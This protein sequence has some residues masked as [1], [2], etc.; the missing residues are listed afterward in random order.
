MKAYYSTALII[1]ALFLTGACT[2]TGTRGSTALQKEVDS[3]R[4][5]VAV[6]KNSQ[7][8][9]GP[10]GSEIGDLRNEVRRLSESVDPYNTGG[11]N[12][13][14]KLDQL[15]ARLDKLEKA[16]GLPSTASPSAS[17]A[18]ARSGYQESV[19]APGHYS[20]PSSPAIATSSPVRSASPFEDGR[21]LFDQKDYQ[22][23]VASFQK[24]LAAEPKGANADAAQFY[25]AESL[26]SR[27]RYEEAILEYQKVIQGFPKSS[28]VPTSLLRQAISFQ[29][30]GDK[31]SAKLLYQKVLRDYPKSYAAS[32][33][34]GRLKSI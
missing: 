28:Q 25:I 21:R 24:Y 32:V 16:A 1:L 31:D 19:S 10:T 15:N 9:D 34:S 22:G 18:Q 27:K 20:A 11:D 26:Y 14:Q 4:M 17:L 29:T 2:T 5:E 6:L 7:N 23:A 30:I 33:A 13:T 3:L 12:L 8:A